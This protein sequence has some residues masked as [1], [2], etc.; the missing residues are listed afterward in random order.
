MNVKVSSFAWVPGLALLGWISLPVRSAAAEGKAAGRVIELSE[1]A[2]SEVATNLQQLATRQ[3]GLK[4]LETDQ[5]KALKLFNPD[6]SLEAVVAPVHAPNK[7]AP[8]T[9]KELERRDRQKNWVFMSPEELMSGPTME[10]IFNM[11]EY[12]EDGQEKKKL[13]VVEQFYQNFDRSRNSA[14]GNTN[15]HSSGPPGWRQQVVSRDEPAPSEDGK[16][17]GEVAEKEQ[18]LKKFFG[19]EPEKRP[20]LPAAGRGTFSDIFGFGGSGA[21]P[22]RTSEQ[23]ARMDGFKQLV[24]LP[25][26]SDSR[27]DTFGTFGGFTDPTRRP[28]N[29]LG[30]LDAFSGGQRR[31]G[32][33]APLGMGNPLFNPGG[34]VEVNGRSFAA[35]G[36]Q[37]MPPRVE[38]PKTP[39]PAPA[40]TPPKRSF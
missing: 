24:G 34:S 10:E 9:K 35:P 31:S 29:G 4:E 23:K 32:F 6:D 30:G 33:E 40:F 14:N 39:P 18:A 19:T 13:S 37:Y 12:G 7:P 38:Q 3:Y 8:L 28:G 15:S 36:L 25:S 5:F 27:P 1:P 26:V 11:R 2:S 17:P 21:A 20:L 22:E 16:A